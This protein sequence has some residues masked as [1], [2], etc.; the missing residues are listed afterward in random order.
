MAQPPAVAARQV[1]R[2]LMSISRKRALE[3]GQEA[4][5]LP[6]GQ[7]AITLFHGKGGVTLRYQGRVV[8]RTHAS[9]V[10]RRLAPFLAQALGVDLPPV[11]G[12]ATAVASSRSCSLAAAAPEFSSSNSGL[13]GPITVVPSRF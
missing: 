9:G 6:K 3:R 11:G 10:G 8:A 7:M 2:G 5:E 12:K 13:P 1:R 4:I